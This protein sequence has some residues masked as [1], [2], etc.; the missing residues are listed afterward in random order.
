MRPK[1]SL[2]VSAGSVKGQ[3]LLGTLS[4]QARPTTERV[5]AA[6]FNILSERVYFGQR[7]LDLYAG[8]GS[9]GIE[10]LSLGADYVDFVEKNSRQ[11]SVIEENLTRTG[12]QG[13]SKVH[14]GDS[15][16]FLDILSEPYSLVLLDPPY[17]MTG[18][19]DVVRKISKSHLLMNENSCVVVGHSRR[20][21][22]PEQVEE[23]TLKSHRQY[24]DNV[25]DFFS[26]GE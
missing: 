25:V 8:S 6:I 2:R 11:C 22:L 10:A 1:N 23:L 19:I 21:E 3:R 12:F 15:E 18:L 9:L 17:K 7:A 16:K 26:Y 24:G 5:K 14:C 20:V 13:I 4:V